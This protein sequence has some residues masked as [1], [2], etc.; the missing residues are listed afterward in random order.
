MPEAVLEN[1]IRGYLSTNQPVYTFGWQGGEPMLMGLDFFRR[2]TD[3]QKKHGR[4]GTRIANGIQTNATLINDAAAEH[5]ARY[6]FLI[7]CS[8]DGPA[9]MHDRYRRTTGGE[10]SQAAALKGIYH[11]VRHQVEFN[12]LVLVTQANVQHAKEVY[13]YLVDQG[14]YYHQYIP[15]VEFDSKGTLLP[16]AITGRQWGDFM[17]E[18]FDLWYY[19]DRQTVSVRYFDSI[20]QKLIDGSCN[21]CTLGDNCCQYFVVEYNG[22]IYPCDFFVRED[23]KIGNIRDMSWGNAPTSTLYNDFGHQKSR[24]NAACI[25][26]DCRELCMGDCLKNRLYGN[27]EARNISWL[28]TGWQQLIR[29]TR[30]KLQD[31]ADG[32]RESQ[33]HADQRMLRSNAGRRRVGPSTGRNQ[34]CPCGSGRKYK[35]CCGR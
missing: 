1:L 16:F 25:T 8:L 4:T 21:I 28:C 35:K 7:G 33:I 6:R 10:P 5:F 29:H 18:I 13:R 34:S 20:L 31:I 24:C 19:R 23:L 12:I 26:C 27:S 15:C 9:H 30:D 32:I 22:D 14:F 2:V 3:L 17:C 11:L